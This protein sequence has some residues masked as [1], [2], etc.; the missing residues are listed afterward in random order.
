VKPYYEDS[1]AGI[2]IYNADCREILPSLAKIDCVITDPPYPGYAYPWPVTPITDLPSVPSLYFWMPLLPFPLLASAMHVWSKANVNIG[3]AERYELIYEVGG[4]T[5]CCV[6][7]NSAINCEMNAII[8]GDK[9]FNHPT[10][11]PIKLMKRLINR[12]SGLILDPFIGSG[13]TL[14]AAKDLGRK[15][16]GIE[17][18]EK[19]CEIA[20][21]RL[22]Q[23][24]LNFENVA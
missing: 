22:S 8:N 1:K 2:V 12:M 21:K 10:Q 20:A 13:T 3:D 17:I 6:F 14:R 7:R 16:I 24:V 18:E 23:E 11:K 4:K 19:Y 15:A 9:Y 5:G